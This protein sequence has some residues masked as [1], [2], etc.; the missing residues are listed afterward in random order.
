LLVMIL[1]LLIF[2]G[3]HILPTQ[4]E[5]RNGLVH[6]FGRAAYMGLFSLVS[7]IGLALIVLGYAKLHGGPVGKNPELWSPPYWLRH[8]TML[9]LIPSMILLVATYVP[10]RI[11]TA[12]RH[13][14]LAAIKLWALGHLLVNG[15]LASILLFGSFLAYA[16]YDRISVKHRQAS[17]PLGDRKGGLPGD[18]IVVVGGL[19]L[20]VAL[21]FF[22][23]E[24]LF[25]VPPM[26]R[27]A[28]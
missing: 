12:A 25:G 8:I 9:L 22:L 1:G 23:H 17:G 28:G 6:R 26:A 14:M 7:A 27:M 24:W 15:D 11:R 18:I 19:A 3:I 21:V 16:V 5:L 2:F 13:P 4:V 10:S 20:Y